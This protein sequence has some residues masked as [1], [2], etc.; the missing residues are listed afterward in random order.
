MRI[1]LSPSVY[2]HAARFLGKTPWEVSRDGEL[3]YTIPADTTE[4]LDE[5]LDVDAVYYYS[6]S[7]VYNDATEQLTPYKIEARI[8]SGGTGEPNDPY[9]V[10]LADQLFHLADHRHLWDKAYVLVNDID[11]HPDQ[12]PR[13]PFSQ[14]VIHHFTGIF[15]GNDHTISNLMITGGKYLGLFGRLES[16]AQVFDLNVIEVNMNGSERFVGGLAVSSTVP[17]TQQVVS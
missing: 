2:E 10:A 7:V 13:A 17:A 12:T 1:P 8:F 11:L 15:D 4:I 9:Q 5:D 16:S 3:V 6:V 14:A